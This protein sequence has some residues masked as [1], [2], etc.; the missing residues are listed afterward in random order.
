MA[1]RVFLHV[2]LPKTGTTYLQSILWANKDALADQDLLLPGFS[3]RQHL[4]ASGVVREDP[5]LSRR[6]PRAVH[7]WTGLTEEINGWP[8]DALVSHEFFAGASERQAARAMVDLEDAEVHV[9]VTAREIVSLVTARW[10]EYVKNG[11]T[12]PI[13]GYP[14]SEEISPTQ[15]WDWGTMDVADVLR[16]WGATL[17]PERVHVLTMPKSTEPR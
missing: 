9:V 12:V 6:S 10:Q 13:D 17:P 8:G 15:E 1:A 16:R 3:A 4:W 7:A 11:S 5:R 14:M 2:G